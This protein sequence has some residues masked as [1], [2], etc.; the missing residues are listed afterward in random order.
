MKR[1][2]RSVKR[3]AKKP[4]VST[5]VPEMDP[6]YY[7]DVNKDNDEVHVNN[8][9]ETKET[10]SGNSGHN[11][12]F[13]KSVV[14][15]KTPGSSAANL[16]RAN[17]EAPGSAA[18][19]LAR[20]LSSSRANATSGGFSLQRPRIGQKEPKSSRSASVYNKEELDA[21]ESV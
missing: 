14:N 13:S 5:N 4:S 11:A 17:N 3:P 2:R 8:E 19:Q 7:S 9:I 15:D 6:G 20:S 1:K 12:N 18:A 10:S 16:A 21:A